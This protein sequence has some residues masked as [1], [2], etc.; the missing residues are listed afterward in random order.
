MNVFKYWSLIGK[1]GVLIFSVL[2]AVSSAPAQQNTIQFEM[3]SES[4]EG[5]VFTALFDFWTVDEGGGL[6]VLPKKNAEDLVILTLERTWPEIKA[7]EKVR[8]QLQVQN[9]GMETRSLQLE[10]SLVNDKKEARSRV[11]TVRI[12]SR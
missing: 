1:I 9:M 4:Q 3:I 5:G 6:T 12:P 7:G 8:Y 10:L 11:L 2:L